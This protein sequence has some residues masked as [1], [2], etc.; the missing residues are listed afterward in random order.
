M[1]TMSDK[2]LFILAAAFTVLVALT[3]GYLCYLNPDH[4]GRYLLAMGVMGVAWT[5]RY[6]V[7]PRAADG[8]DAATA[9]TLMPAWR[10]VT[11]SIAF[12]GL[13]LSAAL[14]TRLGMDQGYIELGSRINGILAGV[15]V[16]FFANTIPKQ[17]TSARFLP[18]LRIAGWAL[19]LG[20]LGFSLSWIVLPLAYANDVALLTLLIAITYATLRIILSLRRYPPAKPG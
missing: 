2:R 20:G 6:V 11:Q 16:V 18:M 17:V 10:K 8:V 12:A 13:L 14:I 9:A 4:P 15:I 5:F 19:V 1:K 3:A 7:R